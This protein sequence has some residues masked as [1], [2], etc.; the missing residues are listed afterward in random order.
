MGR[1]VLILG[2][3]P[4]GLG[5]AYRLS[6]GGG[7]DVRLLEQGDGFGGNAR[8]LAWKGHRIDLGS[9]RLP[10]S[11][12]SRVLADLHE[13]LE[14]DL[15]TRPRMA[16]TRKLGRWVR[17]PLR[18]RWLLRRAPIDR[19]LYPRQGIGQISDRMA[20]EARRRGADLRVRHRVTQVV[21]RDGGVAVTAVHRNETV[22][23]EAE[24][25]LSTLA[26]TQ[27][28]EMLK[29]RPPEEVIRAAARIRFHGLV[30]VFLEFAVDRFSEFDAFYLPSDQ[31]R[32]SRVTEPKVFADRREPT[33]RTV[34]TAEI[35]CKA[36]GETWRLS[37]VELAALV[38]QELTRAHLELPGLPTAAHVVRLPQAMPIL[39]PESDV[40]LALIRSHLAT[41]ERI[42]SV[43]NQGNLESGGT[44]DALAS[45]Y[46]AVDSLAQAAGA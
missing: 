31:Y 32:V 18:P 21:E 29:P 45:A 20:D 40:P 33:G 1:G 37:D 9:H 25:V 24:R 15:L 12:D 16:R 35:P 6:R 39:G 30:L 22:T 38:T 41:R 23:F 11:A 17:H 10:E 28:V 46:D 36:G 42:V 5:A 8:T 13:L 2:G 14:D 19:F 4:A 43:G 34:L 44:I 3:G 27:M 7:A 26:V